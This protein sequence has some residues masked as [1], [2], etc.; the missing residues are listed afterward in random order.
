VSGWL[1]YCT[2][3]GTWRAHRVGNKCSKPA[4]QSSRQPPK[5]ALRGRARP[6]YG[7][8]K[9]RSFAVAL[10]LAFEALQ[11]L[12]RNR[13]AQSR[14]S[15]ATTVHNAPPTGPLMSSLRGVPA[16][17]RG[18]CASRALRPHRHP[19]GHRHPG[20][21]Q[22]SAEGFLSAIHTFPVKGLA[23]VPMEHAV[24]SQSPV[25]A[26]GGASLSV[27]QAALTSVRAS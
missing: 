26:G 8:F 6:P 9:I 22:C 7:H 16:L 12:C 11:T 20:A 27:C 10:A 4:N 25:D 17:G 5:R 1:G 19:V 3:E 14:V 24:R 15:S 13:S 21:V 18:P 23:A 2:P